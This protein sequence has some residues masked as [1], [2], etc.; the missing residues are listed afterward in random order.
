[1]DWVFLSIQI[2]FETSSS[3]LYYPVS[4][5][6]AFLTIT[7]C[8]WRRS[9]FFSRSALILVR[10]LNWFR[11]HYPSQHVLYSSAGLAHALLYEIRL[12][13]RNAH[14]HSGFSTCVNALRYL[15]FTILLEDFNNSFTRL[16]EIF[17]F[18]IHFSLPSDYNW[19]QNSQQCL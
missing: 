19:P 1:M 8:N 7:Q 13:P 5:G 11:R 9:I 10:A 14:M 6:E 3:R 17:W 12:G 18:L 16:V 15:Y 2:N 4:S